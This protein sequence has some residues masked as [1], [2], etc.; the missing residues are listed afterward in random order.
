MSATLLAARD[1]AERLGIT[2]EQV[3]RRTSAEKWPCVRFS[4]RTIRYRE[5]H[6]EQIIALHETRLDI[7]AARSGQTTRSRARSG[8]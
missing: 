7:A 5:E 6:V 8:R 3:K 2:E 1:V 4:K